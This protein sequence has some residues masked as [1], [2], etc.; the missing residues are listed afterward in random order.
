MIV[1]E[2]E[3]LNIIPSQ[4]IT[5]TDQIVD[6]VLTL[7]AGNIYFK[8]CHIILTTGTILHSG[9]CCKST[10][11]IV[12]NTLCKRRVTENILW[13]SEIFHTVHPL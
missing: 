4:D 2:K 1:K 13:W 3:D 10:G 6:F 12:E 7:P 11:R 5:K 8:D 9:W